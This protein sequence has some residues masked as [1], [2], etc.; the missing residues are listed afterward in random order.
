MQFTV[1]YEVHIISYN[2]MRMN[3]FAAQDK[4]KADIESIRGFNFNLSLCRKISTTGTICFAK[5]GLIEDS[6]IL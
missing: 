2:I 1:R 4:V 5:L 3:M 6:Y